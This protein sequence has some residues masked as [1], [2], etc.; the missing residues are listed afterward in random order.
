MGRTRVE[1]ANLR[2]TSCKQ[3]DEVALFLLQLANLFF[4][5][6]IMRILRALERAGNWHMRDTPVRVGENVN[7]QKDQPRKAS[8]HR[9][10]AA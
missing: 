7:L 6:R 8:H 3:N 1:R 4:L 5:I 9:A 10:E 2:D